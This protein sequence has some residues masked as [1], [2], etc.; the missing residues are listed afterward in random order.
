MSYAPFNDRVYYTNGVNIGYVKSSASCL[1]SDPNLEF[2]LP[3]PPG[4]L[5]EYYRGRL[6]IARRNILYISDPLC[7]Y[8]DIRSGYKQ[9]SGD[10]TLL[11]AVDE[12]IYVG[13]DKVWWVRG[14]SPEEFERLE[15]YSSKAIP[16][17][18]IRTNGQ[19]IGEGTTKGNIAIWTGENGICAGSSD[20]SVA[21][22]TELRYQFIPRGRGAGFIREKAN[23]RHYINS[24]F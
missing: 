23:V 13:D 24:L 15:V 21:N 3:L 16:F 2:K 10:I 9:F 4:Q 20:G 18:D 11:R 22:L 19:N 7:D 5:I 8:F 1:L 14:D 6:Y 12:G 17:T